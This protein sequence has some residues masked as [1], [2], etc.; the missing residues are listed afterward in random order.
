MVQS[1]HSILWDRVGVVLATSPRIVDRFTELGLP[2]TMMMLTLGETTQQ[3][4]F[5]L[6]FSNVYIGSK[7]SILETCRWFVRN[8]DTLL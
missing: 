3:H 1:V 4:A 7:G 2:K 5:S 6:G 8:W